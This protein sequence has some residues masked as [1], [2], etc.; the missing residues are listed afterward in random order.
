MKEL[1]ILSTLALSTPL[2]AQTDNA[3]L[4]SVE[5]RAP[6]FDTIDA[7]RDGRITREEASAFSALEVVFDSVDANKDGALST[8]EFSRTHSQ[9]N[10]K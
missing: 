5:S 3:A 2:L 9:D 8:D 7:D 1:F 4:A 10:S 6:S